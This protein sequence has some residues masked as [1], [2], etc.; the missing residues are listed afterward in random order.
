[1]VVATDCLMVNAERAGTCTRRCHVWGSAL[2]AE[3]WPVRCGLRDLPSLLC[4]AGVGHAVGGDK[5]VEE[6]FLHGDDGEPG[7]LEVAEIRRVGTEEPRG[8]PRGSRE[9]LQPFRQ[10]DDSVA[11]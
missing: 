2:I 7:V 10:R 1:M 9:P 3:V 11:G 8:R 6:I 5:L 4:R